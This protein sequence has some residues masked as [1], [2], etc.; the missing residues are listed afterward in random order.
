MVLIALLRSCL[1]VGAQ[2]ALE[3]SDFVVLAI[4]A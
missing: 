3:A 4:A 2:L 1:I